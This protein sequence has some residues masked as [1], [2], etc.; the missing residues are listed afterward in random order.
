MIVRRGMVLTFAGILIGVAAS[1]VL[2]RFVRSQLFG[3]QP[4]D[5]LTIACVL[6]LMTFVAGAAAY[7]PARRAAQIDPVVA[8]RRH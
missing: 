5:P 7:L 2:S 3:V 8:L 6:A 1:V 4:S